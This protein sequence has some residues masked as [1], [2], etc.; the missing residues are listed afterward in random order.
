MTLTDPDGELANP[1]GGWTYTDAGYQNSWDTT[2]AQPG[3]SGILVNYTG[4]SVVDGLQL[5]HVYG[6]SKGSKAVQ[7]AQQ[8]LSQLET[9]FPGITPY[10]NGQAAESISHLSPNYLSSYSYYE[11]GQY[12]AFA[13]YERVRQVTRVRRCDSKSM[14]APTASRTTAR[15]PASFE[16]P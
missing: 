12:K 9:V 3:T 1:G 7:D 11:P 2:R 15:S 4:G 13:S 14:A 6:N 10:W 8:F 16:A 5:N